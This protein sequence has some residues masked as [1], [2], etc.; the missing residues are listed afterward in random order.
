MKNSSFRF[1]AI[2]AVLLIAAAA[3]APIWP[4][5]SVGVL[6]VAL[7]GLFLAGSGGGNDAL[8]EFDQ[9]LQ[10]ISK[11]ELV[12]RIPHTL[13]DP[14]LNQIRINL[15]S[16][17][18]QTETAFR[19][20]LGGMKASAEERNFRRLQPTGL[21]GTFKE[22]LVQ[23]Q[24]MVDQ[25]SAS[26]ESIAREA[27]L[28]RVFLRS[29]KGLSMAIN[30]TESA[31]N[32]VCE[33]SNS[34]Q[35]LAASFADSSSR[36]SSVA[37]RMSGALGEAQAAAHTGVSALDD[38]NVKSAAI[39]KMSAQIDNIA[40]QT[41]LLALNAAIEAARAGETGRG[42]AVVADEVRKL[43]D[44]CQG[45]AEEITK[46][47][48]EILNSLAGA[49]ANIGELN[50]SVTNARETADEFGIELAQSAASASEVESIARGIQTGAESVAKSIGLVGLAQKAR[51]DVTA[52]LHGENANITS[53]GDMEKKEVVSIVESKRW[54][55]G[56]EDRES[57]VQIYDALFSSIES[58]I[59]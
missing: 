9:L 45:S 33:Q 47:I 27:L 14:V 13:D 23:V 55:N 43:A 31:L 51:S 7:V 54:V 50:A 41:N 34:S 20:I 12:H 28:S 57:L 26:R 56:S 37:T 3:L 8:T 16:A 5:A 10:K 6:A 46:A 49:T 58:Q 39:Q 4:W 59:Q 48:S 11:G 24:V 44:Q 2:G 35:H 15:N 40:K 29:E 25:V 30:H 32:T 1:K 53:L 36:M 22:V 18:D 38:L 19:E 21:H 42:F 17:L 52:L